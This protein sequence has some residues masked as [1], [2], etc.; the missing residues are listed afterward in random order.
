MTRAR[1]L[2]DEGIIQALKF[3]D[4]IRN[5]P[6]ALLQVSERL[7]FD[8]TTSEYM[9]NAPEVEHNKF[10]TRRDAAEYIE[11]FD[12]ALDQQVIDDWAFW[13]WL[14]MYHFH[15]IIFS[16]ERQDKFSI[17]NLGRKVTE[18]ETIVVAPK[19]SDARRASYRHY[20]RSSW[21]I[22]KNYREQCGILLDQDIMTLPETTRLILNSL[23]VFN[24]VGVVPLI[25]ELYTEN[26]EQKKGFTA[27][28]PGNINRFFHVL[29][30]LECTYDVYGMSSE[31]LMNILPPEFD[32][33]KPQKAVV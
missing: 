33:W 31:A 23:R 30:Q 28:A 21:L 10:V 13:S 26:N 2:T 17:S 5:D 24:S 14:G 29:E 9:P 6:Q 11:K 7:L 3:L 22:N 1:R 25:L 15:D 27:T 4:I 12:P 8:D 18:T 16:D 32:Q 19:S 20:L